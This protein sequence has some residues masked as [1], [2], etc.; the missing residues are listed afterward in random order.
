MASLLAVNLRLRTGLVL[1]EPTGCLGLVSLAALR[2]PGKRPLS[3][4]VD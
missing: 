1:Y 2:Q 3:W 4:T